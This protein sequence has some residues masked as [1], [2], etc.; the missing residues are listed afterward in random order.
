MSEIG[1][2]AVQNKFHVS[3]PM[4]ETV[5]LGGEGKLGNQ[6]QKKERGTQNRRMG[7][8]EGVL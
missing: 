2:N 1:S 5:P 7:K 6:R 3:T 4:A 8:R